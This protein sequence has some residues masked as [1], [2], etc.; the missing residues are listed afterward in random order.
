MIWSQHRGSSWSFTMSQPIAR[1]SISSHLSLL[2]FHSDQELQ[3]TCW[4]YRE[5][6][7]LRTLLLSLF[8]SIGGLTSQYR[9]RQWLWPFFPESKVRKMTLHNS[10]K[11]IPASFSSL[12]K[13]RQKW[14][15]KDI[16]QQEEN[17]KHNQAVSFAGNLLNKCDFPFQSPS[18]S[19]I[20]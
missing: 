11:C 16:F 17:E 20:N 10:S 18:Y 7:S 9:P 15:N 13:E 12:C 2:S 1:T 3:Q 5:S 19:W 14:K 8:P 6:T 4:P